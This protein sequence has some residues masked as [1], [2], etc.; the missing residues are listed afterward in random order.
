MAYLYAALGFSMFT[1]IFAMFQM[2]NALLKQQILSGAPDNKY[3][4]T[5]HQTNDRKFL[6]VLENAN[7]TWGSGDS[8]C[9]R[10]KNEISNMGGDLLALNQYIPT[11]TN[12]SNSS[13]FSGTCFLAKGNHRILITPNNSENKISL[14][15]CVL[16]QK[17]I[18]DF[19]KRKEI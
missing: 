8:L 13:R 15:S 12:N 7:S 11:N 14:F 9:Q 3:S 6:K 4:Q 1:G 19:E 10:I 5:I 16:E 18:C 2:S 17:I